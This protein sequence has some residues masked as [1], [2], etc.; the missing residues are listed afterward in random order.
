MLPLEKYRFAES[1]SKETTGS[2]PLK[3]ALFEIESV[4]VSV[5]YSKLTTP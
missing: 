4:I 5:R 3:R 1:D 2:R